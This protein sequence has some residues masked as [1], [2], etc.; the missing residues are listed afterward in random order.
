MEDT[1]EIESTGKENEK[2]WAS[3]WSVR[4]RA[5]NLERG[6]A[7]LGSEHEMYISSL[8][9]ANEKSNGEAAGGLRESHRETS[10]RAL[11][12]GMRRGE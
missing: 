12:L 9:H 7:T 10:S 11:S 4:Q 3:V 5:H 1:Q 8:G 6:K 2:R